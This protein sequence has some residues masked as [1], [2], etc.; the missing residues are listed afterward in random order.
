MTYRRLIHHASLVV[1]TLCLVA[2]CAAGASVPPGAS[3]P[4]A[5]SSATPPAPTDDSPRSTMDLH[6]SP[7][8]SSPVD[9]S[10][11][12][13]GLLAAIVADAA[14]RANVAE[15][16]VVLIRAERV[17]WP[18]GALG[19]PLP[20]HAYTQA[21]VPGSWVV[22]RAGDATFDYRAP[23]RGAFVLCAQPGPLGSASGG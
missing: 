5:S 11:L 23:D 17:T 10:V 4:A 19:C 15:S 7:D 22:V 6:R 2:A 21:L 20:G 14:T 16:A 9:P 13:A 12:P 1:A 3:G 8:P 18:D